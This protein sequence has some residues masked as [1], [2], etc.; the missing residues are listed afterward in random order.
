MVLSDETKQVLMT[1]LYYSPDTQFTSIKSLF[2]ALKNK[3][4]TYNEVRDFV[5]KQESNQLFLKR[6]RPKHFF[7]IVAK[8]KYEILQIDLVDMSDIA[9]A[10]RNYKYLLVAVDVFSRLAF[11]VPMKN[12]KEETITKSM[13]EIV[14]LTEPTI[15]NCDLG[16]EFISEAFNKL[17]KNRGTTINYVNVGD[18]HKLAIVDRF[19]RTI[20]EKINKYM[21]MHNTT[22][23]IDV[24]QKIIYNYNHAYH[25]GIKKKPIDVK[26]EDESI[27]ELTNRKYNKAKEEEI[28]YDINDNVR[29]IINKVNFLKGTLPKWSKTVHKIVDKTEHSYKLD[30]GKSYKYYEIQKV[31]DVQKLQKQQKEPTREQLRQQNTKTRRF[32]RTGL[33]TS[34]IITVKRTPQPIRKYQVE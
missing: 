3:H 29:Y 21:S 16:S 12:K 32:N 13:K 11:V 5:Q 23:Y 28:K 8:Y 33:T 9:T 27:I 22:N 20:R 7:P 17:L 31:S 19:V 18:H 4:I 15:I 10:N 6:K 14:D 34:D 2:D 30:N 24:L 25:S 1:N 26:E